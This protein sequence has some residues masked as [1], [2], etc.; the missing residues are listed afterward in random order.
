MARKNIYIT[1]CNVNKGGEVFYSKVEG[2]FVDVIRDNRVLHCTLH[3]TKY[4]PHYPWIISLKS[5]GVMI[6][7]SESKQ[8]CKDF[9]YRN[10]DKIAGRAKTDIYTCHIAPIKMLYVQD[11]LSKV[12]I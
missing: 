8:D 9:V 10:F 3:K 4:A 11:I 2:Y 6:Y 5:C 7:E 1:C 12:V